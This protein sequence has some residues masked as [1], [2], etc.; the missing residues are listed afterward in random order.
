[1]N[2]FTDI[3]NK[4]YYYYYYY[5]FYYKTIITY[6]EPKV[7]CRCHV[8]VQEASMHPAADKPASRTYRV[9]QNVALMTILFDNFGKS[10]PF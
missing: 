7:S 10:T 2:L 5:Y 3:N 1:M 4:Y 8:Q 6:A 9:V